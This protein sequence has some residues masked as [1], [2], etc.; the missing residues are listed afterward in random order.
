M[1]E[2]DLDTALPLKK[3]IKKTMLN[4]IEFSD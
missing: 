2:E 1:I 3:E 4:F